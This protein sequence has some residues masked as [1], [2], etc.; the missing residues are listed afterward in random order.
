MIILLFLYYMF[1]RIFSSLMKTDKAAGIVSRAVVGNRQ[2][3]ALV[4]AILFFGFVVNS[5]HKHR[6]N[7]RRELTMD[8][9]SV[10]H[11]FH[12]DCLS[13]NL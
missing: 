10:T 2:T 8:M 4:S 11:F 5:H 12:G 6:K 13:H 9:A 3:E 1:G 7:L